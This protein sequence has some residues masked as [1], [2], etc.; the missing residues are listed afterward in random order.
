M[1]SLTLA[2]SLIISA[3]LGEQVKAQF[4]SL[5]DPCSEAGNT[6]CAAENKICLSK[7]GMDTCTECMAGFVEFFEEDVCVSIDS[8]TIEQYVDQYDPYHPLNKTREERDGFLQ[9]KLTVISNH[10]SR[11]PAPLYT[12]EVNKFTASYEEETLVSRGYLYGNKT[13]AFGRFVACRRRLQDGATYPSSIDW[14][15]RGA[16]TPVKDQA[17]CG[18]C[19]AFATA[20][21]VEG[22][23]AITSN[24]TYLES[25]S[26]QQFISCDTADG[27]NGCGGG[28]PV[29]ALTYAVDN[30]FGGLASDE[31]YPFVDGK[32][33]V[34]STTCELV[35]ENKTLAVIV[36]E[37]KTVF[38]YSDSLTFS[39]RVDMMK[40]AVATGP[41][42]ITMDANCDTIF[43]Y[44][45]GI[46]TDPGDC[47]CQRT[48]C[49][50]HAV[51]MVV[52]IFMY[53]TLGS[54]S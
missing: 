11:I 20:G 17:N 24:L 48:R 50:D 52:S 35:P 2:L 46:L 31:D 39:E 14:V 4:F 29:N 37:P 49:I 23:A 42:S 41:V 40:Q 21:V 32:S 54:C 22:A 36:R 7:N 16:V 8:V 1:K 15:T 33:G 6:M 25:Y 19:W 10:N 53:I 28:D 13:P 30:S 18:A 51:L 45:G 9:A 38:T 43:N 26:P 47:F 27:N 34:T 44:E 3:L 12:L 5:G